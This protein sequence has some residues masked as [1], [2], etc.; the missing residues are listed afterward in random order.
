M[1]NAPLDTVNSFI[2]ERYGDKADA[3]IAAV[4]QAY[5]DDTM[6]TDLIEVDFRFRRGTVIHAN[7]KSSNSDAPVFMY[8]FT[9]QS[10][11]FDGD[12]KSAHCIELPFVFNNVGLWQEMTGGGEDAYV[13]EDKVSQA[14]INFARNGDPNH[15]GLPT[16]QPYTEENVTTM[17]FDNTCFIRH[18]H[19]KELLKVTAEE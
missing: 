7:L 16:W 9:W 14:W 15:D 4:K 1:K 5:P 10:P 6:P 12:Y 11:L 3:Y 8:M 18:H 19:D 13:L 17:F 2:Q